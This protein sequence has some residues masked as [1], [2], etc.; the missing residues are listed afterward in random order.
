MIKGF[1]NSLQSLGA[2]DG[3]GVRFVVFLQGCNL[4]CGCCHN[5]ETQ[6]TGGTEMAADELL[7]KVVRF[8]EYFGSEGGITLSGGEPLLQAAFA[9]EVFCLCKNEG[10]NTCLDTSGSVWNEDVASLLEVTDHILLDIKYTNDEDYRAFAG[11][12]ME[13]V[14]AFLGELDKRGI[15][16]TL[17]QVIITTL[18][19]NADNISRL[20]EIKNTHACVEKIELL[21]FKKMCS[22]KYDNLGREFPFAHLPTP[23]A[24]QMNK[25]NEL[26]K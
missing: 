18:N 2:S 17:R 6:G 5:P 21:P 12:D 10:I 14:L 23:T 9:R 3:P 4:H 20:R 26:L 24:E 13:R 19:D 11:C 7:N 16:T 1:V 25:L 22:V 8:R 15:P